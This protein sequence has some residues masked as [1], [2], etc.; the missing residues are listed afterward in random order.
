VSHSESPVS[1]LLAEA[2]APEV[3]QGIFLPWIRRSFA[4]SFPLLHQ[5]NRA[6]L[7]A[8][9]RRGLNSNE[10]TLALLRGIDALEGTP[11]DEVEL[12]GALEDVYFNYEAALGRI[13]GKEIGG[14]LH[15]ARSR[16]DLQA[17]LDRIRARNLGMSL[18][19]NV[20]R[21]R[22]ALLDQAA[23]HVECVMPGYTH[24]QHAQPI[25]F[26]Y[27]LAGIEQSLQRDTRRLLQAT[28]EV[29]A[30]PLGAGALAG[31]A[32]ALDRGFLAELLGFERPV[33][34][35]LDAVASKD[36][37]VE[38]LAAALFCATTIGRMAQDFYYMTTFEFGMLDLPDGLAITSSLM[39]QKKNQAA[40]EFLKGRPSH[41]LGALTTAF[42]AIRGTSF[43]HALDAN[44][45]SLHW[46]WDALSDLNDMLPAVVLLVQEI[47]PR[48]ERMSALASANFSIAT[49]LADLL[50]C[51]AGLS[52]KQ[53]HG[54]AGRVV[55][56]A[57]AAGAGVGGISPAL[58]DQ[59]AREVLARSIDLDAAALRSVLDPMQAVLR[60]RSSGG[61]APDDV[62]DVLAEA[63]RRLAQ[64]REAVSRAA[65]RLDAA[66]SLLRSRSIHPFELAEVE[67]P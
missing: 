57:M 24:M 13:V 58:I 53:A 48:R 32:F 22:E 41:L 56:L 20:L 67:T 43:S 31:T 29:N 38:L 16:N 1:S 39:P 35:A 12:D 33:A 40:L 2:L 34:H 10:V 11:V 30:C 51:Q 54:V 21:A 52:A 66:C 49:D 61:P 8:L 4:A 47:R 26:G 44:A 5:I 65:D 50:V 6:H 55:R 62:Q 17:T 28:Q 18:V 9:H 23:R 7:L 3:Q 15:K 42:A 37:I 63:R 46:T 14:H 25:T 59:A 64:D 27:Y 36:S 45:D 60:R 19:S